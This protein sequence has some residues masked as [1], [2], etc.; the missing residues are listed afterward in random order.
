MESKKKL[1]IWDFDGV[2]ADSEYLWIENW[3][4]LLNQKFGLKWDFKTA[5]KYLGGISPKSKI[6]NLQK[7]DIKI[8]EPFLNEL[9]KLDWYAVE[10][11]MTPT[12]GVEEIFELAWPQC[13]AT[14]GNFDKTEHKLKILNFEKYFP[15]QYIF[16]SQMVEHGKPEPDLFLYAAEK[17]GFLPQDCIV[18]EDSIAGLKAGLAA[19]MHTIAFVGAN[20][21]QTPEHLDEIAKLKI[22]DIFSDMSSLRNA[23]IDSAK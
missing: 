3:Q 20:M 8:D 12:Q 17:M 18:I 5:N 10:N 16:T 15:K 1:L 13:I 6:D 9:K 11:L 14:G 22:E 21:N 7:F 23:L 2:I 19:K 4:K